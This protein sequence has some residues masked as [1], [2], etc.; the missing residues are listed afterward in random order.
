LLGLTMRNDKEYKRNWYL[1]NRDRLLAQGAE[2]RKSNKEK[3]K[4]SYA[5]WAKSN[6]E[7]IAEI[8]KRWAQL[9]KHKM[10]ASRKKYELQHYAE[11]L[12]Y[13]R[14]R[15]RRLRNA[16]PKWLTKEQKQ[17]IKQVYQTCPRNKEVDHIVPIKGLQVCGLHVPWNLQHLSV[18]ENRRKRNRH[19]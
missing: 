18:S 17:Q 6:K 19:E 12:L 3:I 4:A 7:K 9:N 8:R 13:T 10:D 2:Y 5:V 1:K 14:M 16:T 15:K 11:K